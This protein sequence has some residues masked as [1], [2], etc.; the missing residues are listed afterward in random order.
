MKKDVARYANDVW[1]S[2]AE[3]HRFACESDDLKHYV[4]ADKYEAL[5]ELAEAV[6]YYE[7]PGS[8]IGAGYRAIEA[9]RT[10]LVENK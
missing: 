6:V 5:R 9:L 4:R 8:R 7:W 2:K 10:C 1:M 3:S